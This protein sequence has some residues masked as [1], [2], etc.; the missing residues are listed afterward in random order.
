MH[1]SIV[2]KMAINHLNVQNRKKVDH[3]LVAVAVAVVVVVVVVEVVTVVLNEVSVVIMEMVIVL[4][5]QLIRRSNLMT[6]KSD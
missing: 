3:R 2:V 1:A 4:V 5:K 6:T